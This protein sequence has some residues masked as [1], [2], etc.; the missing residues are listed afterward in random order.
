MKLIIDGLAPFVMP[1][2]ITCGIYALHYMSSPP[3]SYKDAK[4]RRREYFGI[5]F[6]I[7]FSAMTVLMTLMF[8]VGNHEAE[9]RCLYVETCLR[10]LH[11]TA[12]L[13][14]VLLLAAITILAF[15]PSLLMYTFMYLFHRLY[16]GYEKPKGK[17]KNNHTSKIE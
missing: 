3:A 10:D 15:T 9:R 7:I 13:D 11:N 4:R 14:Y 1:A 5:L 8:V 12:L 6:S 16:A 17:P 2:L